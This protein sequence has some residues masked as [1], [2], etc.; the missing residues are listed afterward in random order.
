[1]SVSS[2]DNSFVEDDLREL[3]RAHE[4]SRL[5]YSSRKKKLESRYVLNLTNSSTVALYDHLY[6]I[7]YYFSG[8][9][10]K[11]NKDL[12]Q[13]LDSLNS[14]LAAQVVADN[15]ISVARKVS[16]I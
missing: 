10:T 9:K 1:M 4:E 7:H 6:Q 3:L 13:L 11:V 15:K 14:D 12:G 8:E 2:K 16:I 5:A